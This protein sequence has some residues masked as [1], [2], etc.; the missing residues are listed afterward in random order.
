M[1]PEV[2]SAFL[3]LLQRQVSCLKSLRR[4]RQFLVLLHDRGNQSVCQ[5]TTTTAVIFTRS[6]RLDRISPT[7]AVMKQH[8]L[9][10]AYQ[11]GHVWSQVHLPLPELPSPAEW[12]WERNGQWKPVWATLPKPNKAAKSSSVVPATRPAEG[13]ASVQKQT[14]SVQLRALEVETATA[15]YEFNTGHRSELCL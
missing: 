2:T 3:R 14:F 1:F 15:R 13:C 12:R 10:A 6:C 4:S 11:G 7:S 8:I 9:R 5:S